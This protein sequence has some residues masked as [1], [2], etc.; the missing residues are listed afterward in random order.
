MLDTMNKSEGVRAAK[1][2]YHDVVVV[3]VRCMKLRLRLS[4]TMVALQN[5]YRITFASLNLGPS[6]SP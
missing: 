4:I 3:T 1:I 2:V 5:S 6:L